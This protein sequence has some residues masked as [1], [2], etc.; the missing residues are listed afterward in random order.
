VRAG[1]D[2]DDVAERVRE[3]KREGVGGAENKR[4]QE[5][6]STRH[7]GR[8]EFS[9]E[10]FVSTSEEREKRERQ[11]LQCSSNLVGSSRTSQGLH[12]RIHLQQLPT[13]LNDH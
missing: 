2:I 6:E 12:A 1:R 10:M 5:K 7:T 11:N 9:T 13:R 8:R 3:S 4:E